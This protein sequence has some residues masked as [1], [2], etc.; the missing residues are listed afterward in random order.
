MLDRKWQLASTL[1]LDTATQVHPSPDTR[2]FGKT[3]THSHPG[4]L[5]ILV[6][7]QRPGPQSSSYKDLVIFWWS[8]RFWMSNFGQGSRGRNYT[9]I[10]DLSFPF[11]FR[12]PLFPDWMH[13]LCALEQSW[14]LHDSVAKSHLWNFR[15][16]FAIPELVSWVLSRNLHQRVSWALGDSSPSSSSVKSNELL[17]IR[18]DPMDIPPRVELTFVPSVF[19]SNLLEPSWMLC[20]ALRSALNALPSQAWH[21]QIA[22]T[23]DQTEP[24]A[25]ALV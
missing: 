11:P 1:W 25:V 6:L 2:T 14:S 5:P 7:L 23:L 9:I 24:S 15:C 20:C 10:Y 16:P 3:N 22:P 21:L 18:R 17:W 12:F 19:A 4:A 13:H 8:I